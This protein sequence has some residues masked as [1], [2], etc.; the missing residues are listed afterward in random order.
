MPPEL[1]QQ[2]TAAIAP[3][4]GMMRLMV[5][6]SAA[7]PAPAFDAWLGVSGHRLLERYGMSEIGMGLSNPYAPVEARLPGHVG[8]PLPGVSARVVS[9]DDGVTP[10]PAGEGGA[11]EISGDTVFHSYYKN[12]AATAKVSSSSSSSKESRSGSGS[13]SGSSSGS[14]SGSTTT[15]TT[16]TTITTTTSRAKTPL[17][18]P[19]PHSPCTASST[20]MED[21]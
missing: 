15:T 3:A 1:Q 6:G 19:P 12:P 17:P 14:S 8:Y 16:I 11:L 13:G 7:L 4:A 5:C 9:P 2:S 20:H 10:V 21:G 18:P